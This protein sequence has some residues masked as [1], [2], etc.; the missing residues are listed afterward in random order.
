M[1]SLSNGPGVI[2][3]APQPLKPE[4]RDAALRLLDSIVEQFEPSQAIEKGLKPVS[5]IRLMKEEV[6]DKDSFLNLFFPFIERHLGGVSNDAEPSIAHILTRLDN[7]STWTTSDKSA[8]G[9][10]LVM[11]A[12]FLIDNFFLPLKALATK[13][14]QPTPAS[15]SRAQISEA[16][17]GTPQRISTLRRDCLLRDRHRCVVTRKFDI[18]EAEDRLA[19]DGTD[20]K[21]DDGGSL[22]PE[23]DTMA[24]LEVAHIIPHSF[25]PLTSID[26]E[27][28]LPEHKQTAHKILNMF[29][30]SAIPLIRGTDIDRPMNALTLTHD[31]HMLFGRFEISFEHIGP[32]T[33]KIDYVE[34]DRLFRIVKL[35]VTRTLY[36]TPDNNIG[37]PSVD[38]LNIHCAIAKILHLS[39]AG[40]FIDK[41]LRDMEEMEGGQVMS[42]GTSRI[43]DYVRF[44]LAA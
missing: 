8:L 12:N 35:P 17:V 36:L 4:D 33:Y 23:S 41:F 37:P 13:T 11:F 30:P 20:P 2:V 39:A 42:D 22:L 29:N 5:L 21:D 32:Q 38:L 16:G 24:F 10:S 18:R 14:P 1:S 15:L 25:M 7:F 40:D 3:P 31:L 28:K 19:K 26:G 9:E 44:K 34:R 27:P 43:D 6:S